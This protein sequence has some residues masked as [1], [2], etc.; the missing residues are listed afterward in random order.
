MESNKMRLRKE[1]CDMLC[2]MGHTMEELQSYSMSE[3]MQICQ[4]KMGHESEMMENENMSR[5]E[6]CDML[7]SMGHDMA[8]LEVCSNSE[9]MMMCQGKMNMD[10]NKETMENKSTRIIKSWKNFKS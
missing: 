5:K 8:E 1:M 2:D 7:C 6:M 4:D 10:M 3:L 9:L